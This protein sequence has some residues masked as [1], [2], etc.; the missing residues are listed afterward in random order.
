MKKVDYSETEC[1]IL[2]NYIPRLIEKYAILVNISDEYYHSYSSNSKI[3]L[4]ENHRGKY[5]IIKSH[6]SDT[7]VYWLFPFAK[8]NGR[9]NPHENEILNLFFNYHNYENSDSF[10]FILKKPAKVYPASNGEGWILEKQGIL[11]FSNLSSLESFQDDEKTTQDNPNIEQHA[12]LSQVSKIEFNEYI[13]KSLGEINHLKLQIQQLLAGHHKL[14]TEIQLVKEEYHNLQIMIYTESNNEPDLSNN[15]D[16]E[17]FNLVKNYNQ[18]ANFPDRIEVSETESSKA[19]R[20]SG[21]QKPAIFEPNLT[22]RGEYWIINNQYL[23]PKPK[24]KINLYSYQV[25]SAFFEC[26]NY[27]ENAADNMTLV[28]P[29]QVSL[30]DGEEKWQLEEIGE[31]QF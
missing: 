11:D 5:W 10:K 6:N 20:W 23:V 4:I 9:I 27:E 25:L 2:Y 30:I 28:K 7:D 18:Q 26:D 19:Q 16:N 15:L 14:E 21:G 1:L 24:Q 3:L 29:A 13:D 31:L 12:I 17:V 8:F 22:N